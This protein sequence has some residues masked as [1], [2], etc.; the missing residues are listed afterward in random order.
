MPSDSWKNPFAD[1]ELTYKGKT[2][3][4]RGDE[5]IAEENRRDL[6][7]R[8]AEKRKG[9]KPTPAAAP[10]TEPAPGNT[11][12]PAASGFSI[13][14]LADS[15]RIS[16][17]MLDGEEHV[18]ELD[19]T[20]LDGGNSHTQDE[21]VGLTQ[22]VPSA[23]LYTAMILTLYTNKDHKDSKQKA[24]VEELK[25]VLKQ[26]FI[27]HYMMTSTRVAY[28]PQG[29][30]RV[31]QNYGQPGETLGTKNMTGSNCW[32]KT[33]CGA[34][35]ELEALL[36]TNNCNQL[37]N[38]FEWVS[39]KKPYFWRLNSKPS[40]EDVRAVVLGLGGNDDGFGIDVDI[41]DDGPARGMVASR[42]K[43]TP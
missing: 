23:K 39:D 6:E 43:K 8:I 40:E 11:P 35:N 42:A 28:Q 7:A 17:V 26:D 22:K 38:A 27:S 31:M 24:L 12:P 18:V 3:R 16:G 30:D 4:Q 36:G 13:E 21:W 5:L 25:G 33:G 14:S 15:Y 37:E 41:D 19:K 2:A 20:L 10:A 32:I 29:S 9:K 34:D 1:P